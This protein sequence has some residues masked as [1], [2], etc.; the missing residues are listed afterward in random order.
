MSVNIIKQPYKIDFSKNDIYFAFSTKKELNNGAYSSITYL[1]EKMPTVRGEWME[2][3]FYGYKYRFDVVGTPGQAKQN[4]RLIP[5][6]LSGSDPYENQSIWTDFIAKDYYISKHFKI[7]TTIDGGGLHI[8]FTSK[9][10]TDL[11]TLKFSLS[12]SPSFIFEQEDFVDGVIV[13]YKSNYQ[14]YG[15]IVFG[16][17]ELPEIYVSPNDD[18]I[19]ILPLDIIRSYIKLDVPGINS[20]YGAI[21]CINAVANYYL[22]YS[23]FFDERV[24]YIKQSEPLWLL[25]GRCNEYEQVNNLPDW[26][27]F[28]PL[29]KIIDYKF[30][31]N[32]SS[33]SGLT[34]N[35]YIELEQFVY[36]SLFQSSTNTRSIDCE[37]EILEKSGTFIFHNPGSLVLENNKIYRIP[38]GYN[39]L[40]LYE[41]SNEILMY[42]VRL[43]SNSQVFTRTFRLFQKPMFAREFY[44]QNRHGLFETFYCENNMEEKEIDGT[45]NIRRN[46]IYID[47][48][49]KRTIFTARTGYKSKNEMRLLS[50]AV[51]NSHNFIIDNG[52]VKRIAI[53]PDSYIIKDEAED[54]QAAE[55]RY[56]IS[57]DLSSETPYIIIGG[58]GNIVIGNDGA[59]RYQ[60]VNTSMDEKWEA[61][62]VSNW[63]SV[64]PSTGVGSSNVKIS[65]DK[66]GD[67]KEREGIVRFSSLNHENIFNEIY[68]YQ[69]AEFE[70]PYI[71]INPLYFELSEK[72]NYA[73]ILTIDTNIY[74]KVDNKSDVI[75][76]NPSE[77][78]VSQNVTVSALRY[79]G[80]ESNKY[81][82][83]FVSRDMIKTINME[84]KGKGGIISPNA[85]EY[86]ISKNGGIVKITGTSNEKFLRLESEKSFLKIPSNFLINGALQISNVLIEGDPG[87]FGEYYFEIDLDIPENKTEGYRTA[88]LVIHGENSISSVIITQTNTDFGSEKIYKRLDITGEQNGINFSFVTSQ[89]YILGTSSLYF[90]G[91]LFTLGIDYEETGD[92]KFVLI[93]PPIEN[94]TIIFKA[95]VF[96][97]IEPQDEIRT[98]EI[99]GQQNGKNDI[100]YTEQSFVL[101]SSA[102]Y[103]NGQLLTIGK[104][105]E[106][107][108]QNSFCFLLVPP[109]ES[110]IMIYKALPIKF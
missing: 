2:L 68:I 1:I 80:R 96:D 51:E 48:D 100:F 40:N 69:S 73:Q 107:L 74:W 39:A 3:S 10:F 41:I 36:F 9:I 15:K 23:E 32:Y 50:E 4:G 86:K 6:S 11:H 77:G 30:P 63:I 103:L 71:K 16:E 102:L 78:G 44:F 110:D 62:T 14:I 108:D 61:R 54:L 97:N 46:E 47:I 45:E 89:K 106:E 72:N 66:I 8:I 75:D 104:D 13:H 57:E 79:Q 81:S 92:D 70:N 67:I 37:I 49:Q 53:L 29:T 101:G 5:R 98:M 35:S 26:I 43:T 109:S 33:D 21:P 82:I 95:Y 12:G 84:V 93:N 34:L 22:E 27:T 59:D 18:N 7:E 83:D 64:T 94:D 87:A 90:N 91:Q 55:F 65:I 31:R 85:M 25:P 58:G 52:Q 38:V 42:T 17:N 88:S 76:V 99:S 28:N 105:Y 60:R 20:M 56:Q 24:Q 19:A